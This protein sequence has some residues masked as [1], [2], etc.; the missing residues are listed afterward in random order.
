MTYRIVYEFIVI[1]EK[2]LKIHFYIKKLDLIISLEFKI[3][4]TLDYNI[5]I[6]FYFQFNFTLKIF[7]YKSYHLKINFIY[8]IFVFSLNKIEIFSFKFKFSGKNNQIKK[9]Y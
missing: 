1:L 6:K 3:I 9:F 7:K 8:Y 5:Y 4:F 2:I